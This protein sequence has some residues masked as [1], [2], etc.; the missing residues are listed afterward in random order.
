MMMCYLLLK[1]FGSNHAIQLTTQV[2]ISSV[3]YLNRVAKEQDETGNYQRMIG[4]LTVV[5]ESFH[6]LAKD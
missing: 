4:E 2:M 3:Y 5:I 6:D 1:L